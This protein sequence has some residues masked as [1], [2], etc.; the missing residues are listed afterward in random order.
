MDASALSALRTLLDPAVVAAWLDEVDAHRSKGGAS[1]TPPAS[2]V[3][4]PIRPEPL[5]SVMELSE[6]LGVRR[7][8]IY[9]MVKTN[10]IPHIRIGNRIRFVWTRV[11]EWLDDPQSGRG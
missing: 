7:G 3:R 9:D 11:Q 1:A 8:A 10:E 6:R 2:A 5:L 4:E